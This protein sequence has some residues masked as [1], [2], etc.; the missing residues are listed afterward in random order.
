LLFIHE[1]LTE[2]GREHKLDSKLDKVLFFRFL[3]W[4]KSAASDVSLASSCTPTK[5]AL[6][7]PKL[8]ETPEK[9]ATVHKVR[10]LGIN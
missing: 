4:S 2:I 5:P 9:N 8:L 1:V 3:F 6:L 10:Y 7:A